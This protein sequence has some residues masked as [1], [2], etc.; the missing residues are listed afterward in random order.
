MS[1]MAKV[2]DSTLPT[3]VL[4][5]VLALAVCLTANV[6]VCDLVSRA[7]QPDSATK[8]TS[9][10]QSQQDEPVLSVVL[11]ELA[12]INQGRSVFSTLLLPQAQVV[13]PLFQPPRI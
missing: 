2:L 7:L 5:I 3:S 8:T 4:L 1:R 6:R 11:P 10:D 13:F 12:W 9:I